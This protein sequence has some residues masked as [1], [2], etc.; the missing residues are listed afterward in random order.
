[1]FHSAFLESFPLLYTFHYK[2]P[3]IGLI[4]LCSDPLCQ[5]QDIPVFLSF[6]H[7]GVFIVSL[8]VLWNSLSACS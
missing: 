1:M 7:L 4:F 5:A 2:Y 8:P 6:S 3:T